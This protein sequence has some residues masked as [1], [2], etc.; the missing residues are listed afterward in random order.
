MICEPESAFIRTMRSRINSAITGDAQTKDELVE[1]LGCSI[2]HA[3]EHIEVQFTEEMTW[4]SHGRGKNGWHI[5]HR[6]PCSSFNLKNDEEMRM[7]FHFTNLQPLMG[8]ENLSKQAKFDAS[9]FQWVW[10]GD[11]WIE[12]ESIN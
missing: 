12:I 10:D 8:K 4:S 2:P 5:D 1:L 7:C 3:R 11:M 9:N 6:R